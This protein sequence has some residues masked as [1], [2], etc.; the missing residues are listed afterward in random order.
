V[1]PPLCN[2]SRAATT[3]TL[4]TPASAASQCAAYSPPNN[5]G[6]IVS[7]FSGRPRSPLFWAAETKSLG[8]SNYP[9]LG[10]G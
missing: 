2:H 5:V 7:V 6:R 9:K 8:R 10:Q 3:Q 4:N 1:R